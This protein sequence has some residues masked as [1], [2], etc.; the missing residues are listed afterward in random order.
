MRVFPQLS[1]PVLRN[2]AEAFD[3]GRLTEA[4][5]EKSL[6]ELIKESLVKDVAHEL[7]GMTQSGFSGKLIAQLLRAVAAERE[8]QQRVKDRVRWVW[9]GPS[10]VRFP[11][12]DTSVVVQEMFKA[13]QT[14][15]LLLTYAFDKGPKA[16]KVF[17]ALAD[18][19]TERPGLNV[20]F[21]A[22]LHPLHEQD[23]KLED[24]VSRFKTQFIREVW[25]WGIQPEVYIDPR[26]LQT[27]T[28][29]ASLHA[30]CLVVDQSVAL[31]TSANF[32]DAAH[33]R[34]IEAGVLVEDR[35]TAREFETHVRRL[36]ERKVLV[37]CL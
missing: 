20:V 16:K 18:R 12:R 29:R 6:R 37:R 24:A 31:V 27:S 36:I 23:E 7:R 22:N 2:L 4:L 32:T 26:A 19:M 14:S 28:D 33:E 35:E 10:D 30:K 13:A 15:V 3:E 8:E 1:V 5:E 25:P 34:N 11:S 17:E 21:C 9:S